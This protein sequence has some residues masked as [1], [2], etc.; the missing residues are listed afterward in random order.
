MS[1]NYKLTLQSN[2]TELSSNNLDLQNLIDQANSLPE[3][4]GGS[5]PSNPSASQ[6]EVNFYDYDGTILY[7]YTVEEAQAL[8]E[9]DRKSVV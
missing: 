4:G 5:S 3:V 1:N 2:N 8:T 9:L 6:N 7:S